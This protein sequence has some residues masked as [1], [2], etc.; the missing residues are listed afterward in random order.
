MNSVK[1]FTLLDDIHALQLLYWE[2]WGTTDSNL[3][4]IELNLVLRGSRRVNVAIYQAT[5]ARVTNLD[6]IAK[7]SREHAAILLDF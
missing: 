5:V 6:S 7:K 3:Y 1:D 2:I 4:I